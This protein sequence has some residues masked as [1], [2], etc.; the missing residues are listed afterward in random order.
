MDL[1]VFPS[2]YESLF[3]V[4]SLFHIQKSENPYSLY[5][6]LE[7]PLILG[8]RLD[9]TDNSSFFHWGSKLKESKV[10]ILRQLLDL[11]GENLDNAEMVANFLGTRS[12]RLVSLFLMNLKSTF[13]VEES[14]M[15]K[16]Y[17]SGVSVPDENYF[18]PCLML[19]PKLVLNC[20]T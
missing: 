16:Y 19:S 4:W 17:F 6:L 20:G 1:P 7:E 18:F 9:A 2:F 8:A 13:T 12:I 3:K 5:W 14:L 15:I 10:I 11:A